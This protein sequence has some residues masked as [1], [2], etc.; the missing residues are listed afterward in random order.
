MDSVNNRYALA[1]LSIAKEENKVDEYQKQAKI[2][3]CILN[4][5]PDYLRV[6]SSCFISKEE[7]HLLVEQAFEAIPLKHI[8]SFIKVIIDNNRVSYMKKIF[9]EFNSLCNEY[10]GIAEGIIY[11]VI[12][13]SDEQ[14][15]GISDAISR[16]MGQKVEL[17]NILDEQIIGGI[18]VVIQDRIFDGTVLNKLVSMKNNLLIRK[19]GETYGN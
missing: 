19:A 15:N 13:L 11:S 2:V 8:I 10:L 12:N 7:K 14:I 6:L 17:K 9:Q 18:K 1:L 5:N 16:K 3:Y 4:D